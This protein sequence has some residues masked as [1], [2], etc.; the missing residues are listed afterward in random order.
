MIVHVC[1]RYDGKRCVSIEVLVFQAEEGNCIF[2]L[3]LTVNFKIVSFFF[4][5]RPVFKK[6]TKKY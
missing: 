6:K 2:F 3:N 4:L 1:K 5:K